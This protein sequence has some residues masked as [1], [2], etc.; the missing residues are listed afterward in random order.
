MNKTKRGIFVV[1][2]GVGLW[3]TPVPLGLKVDAWHLFS[4]FAATIAGFILQP[5]PIGSIAFLSI[6]FTAGSGILSS[7][8]I[9]TGFSATNMWLILSAFFFSR[10]LIKS[11][12]GRRIAFKLIKSFGN[13]TLKLAYILALSDLLIAPAT[14]SNTARG[15]GIVFP[16]AGSLAGA[17]SSPPGETAKRMGSYLMQV[18]YQSNCITSAMFMTAMSG[19]PVIAMIA[20]KAVGVELSWGTWAL[21][22]SIPGILSLLIMPYF[23]YKL[24]PPT[25]K[26]TPEAKNIALEELT[27]MGDMSKL[28]K[29]VGLIFSGALILWGTSGYTNIDATIVAMAAVS[30]ML[31]TGVLTWQD[32]LNEKGAWDTF[33]WMGSLVALANFLSKLGFIP[34]L[35]TLISSY[36]TDISWIPAFLILA[37]VYLYSHYGFASMVAHVVAMYAAF[38]AVAVAAGVPPYLAALALAFL[39][40]LCGSLTHYAAGPAPIYFGAGYVEQNE[41]WKQGFLV[42]VLNL[43]VWLGIGGFWWKIIGLW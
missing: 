38:T 2:I 8:D 4:V 17:F 18:G 1:L 29:I 35:A 30:I 24:N 37:V 26:Y 23:L 10:G 16:I 9:L 13:K 34:W 5:I 20:L 6:T 33:V 41:W 31:L 40:S 36:M 7:S 21:A 3:L 22:A 27:S 42:S 19:N 25:V 11:G 12:L 32:I 43:V 14:P 39:S 15:G 28:E